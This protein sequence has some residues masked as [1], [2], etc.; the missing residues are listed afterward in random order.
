MRNNCR[1]YVAK[2]RSTP[3]RSNLR[4]VV[5]EVGV[6]THDPRRV[7]QNLREHL[8]RHDKPLAFLFGA[9]TSAAVNSA[10]KAPKGQPQKFS[11]LIPAMAPLTDICK[12]QVCGTTA[13]ATAWSS[14]ASECPQGNG[15]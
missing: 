4:Y 7:A 10:P 2:L 5:L 13:F 11:P 15:R 9:G 8:A 3:V 14:L 6:P 12:S 1:R